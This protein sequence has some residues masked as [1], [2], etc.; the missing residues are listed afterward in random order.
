MTQYYFT[1]S[2]FVGIMFVLKCSICDVDLTFLYVH[3]SNLPIY[4]FYK[5]SKSY[6][7]Y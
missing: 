2:C 1:F 6:K 4:L 7:A 3:I 5:S